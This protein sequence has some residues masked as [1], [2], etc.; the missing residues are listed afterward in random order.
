[1]RLAWVGMSS[2]SLC[3]MGTPELVTIQ[4]H[5]VNKHGHNDA[6]G[7]F[8]R[9]VIFM[10]SGDA[11]RRDIPRILIAQSSAQAVMNR[12]PILSAEALDDFWPRELLP[13]EFAKIAV[14]AH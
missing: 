4:L 5:V 2:S 9:D 12:L 7:G 10:N 11:A 3:G 14:P 1:M 13:T 6:T 8:I